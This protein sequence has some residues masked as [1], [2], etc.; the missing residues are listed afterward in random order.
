MPA[1]QI[2]LRLTAAEDEALKTLAASM[3]T[4]PTAL[5]RAAI[6]SLA[7][8]GG[9]PARS[10]TRKGKSLATSHAAELWPFV[11]ASLL[12]YLKAKEDARM[13]R[14]AWGEPLTAKE[15][16]NAAVLQKLVDLGAHTLDPDQTTGAE[17][18]TPLG[19]QHQQNP[20]G[21]G[22]QTPA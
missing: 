14:G 9:A 7:Q 17:Y 3:G 8:K 13:A 4:N 10:A 16:I 19:A 11:H 21:A 2:S 12:A 18:I 20:T 6:L 15:F 5:F 1:K 22:Q